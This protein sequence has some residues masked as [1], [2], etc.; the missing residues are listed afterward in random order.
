MQY[1]NIFQYYQ[2]YCK[3]YNFYTKCGEYLKFIEDKVHDDMSEEDIEEMRC[4]NLTTINYLNLTTI[5][6]KYYLEFKYN[7]KL[8]NLKGPANVYIYSDNR[9]NEIYMIYGNYRETNKIFNPATDKYVLRNEKPAIIK[10]DKKGN[11]V[12]ETFYKKGKICKEI[13]YY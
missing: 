6:Y 7:I 11:I 10:Y 1:F 13:K 12:S 8:H 3:L 4:L 9:M 5:N 2:R